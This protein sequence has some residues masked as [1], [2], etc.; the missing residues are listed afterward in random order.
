MAR[1]ILP[2]G[3]YVCKCLPFCL[4]IAVR[5][6]PGVAPELE[7]AI[8]KL[9]LLDVN[10]T[11]RDPPAHLSLHFCLS[12]SITC[13]YSDLDQMTRIIVVVRRRE[14]YSGR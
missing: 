7:L 12:I 4:S 6:P 5:V 10:A 11:E 1:W 14:D 3:L 9:C 2:L 8:L 13:G